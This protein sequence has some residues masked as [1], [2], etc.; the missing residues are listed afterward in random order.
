MCYTNKNICKERWGPMAKK[1]KLRWWQILSIIAVI[2]TVI[3]EATL[4]IQLLR[5]NLLPLEYTLLLVLVFLLIPVIMALVQRKGRKKRLRHIVIWLL[6]IVITVGCGFGVVALEKLYGTLDTITHL[7]EGYAYIGVYVRS[8]DPAQTVQDSKDYLFAT[9]DSD[10]TWNSQDAVQGMSLLLNKGIAA[11]SYE[12]AFAMVDALRKGNVDAVLMNVAYAELMEEIEGYETFLSETRLLYE[13]PVKFQDAPQ[14][15]QP[16]AT[17][18]DVD[19][20]PDAPTEPTQPP[21]EVAV[22]EEAFIIYLSGSDTRSSKLR[23]SRSDVNIL[24]VVNPNTHQVLLVNTPRDYYVSMPTKKNAMDKLTH[25]GLYG[26]DCSAGALEAL[27][28]CDIS[29]NAQI[30]FSGFKK[31]I[32]AVGGVTVNSDVAF[33]TDDGFFIQKGDNRLNG[34]EALSFARERHHLA[35]GDNARGKNQ[36]KVIAAV[37]DKVTSGTTIITKYSQI[38]DSLEGMFV[39]SMPME[40]ISQLIQMQLADMPGWDIHSYAVTGSHDSQ[41]TYSIPGAYAYVMR[42]NQKTVDHASDLI[43]RVMDGQILTDADMSTPK[44]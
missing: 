43:R 15:T 11:E 39:T 20:V 31:M 33:T 13:L 28:D 19:E 35:G 38:L 40:K 9:T 3:A 27:Y 42:P 32:D 34:E 41:K 8:D 21:A 36:M 18:P 22:T 4:V 26:L 7:P 29:Y 12:T 14:T 25:C 16:V 17:D 10:D 2:L 24:A 30:N 44:S 23:R 37:I 5:V 1:K 6:T